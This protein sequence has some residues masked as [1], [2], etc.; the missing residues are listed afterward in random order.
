MPPSPKLK[1]PTDRLPQTMTWSSDL[2]RTKSSTRARGE[3]QFATSQSLFVQNS[4]RHGSAP[5]DLESTMGRWWLAAK[6]V[7]THKSPRERPSHTLNGSTWKTSTGSLKSSYFSAT[8][9]DRWIEDQREVPDR[10][11][12]PVLVRRLRRLK[13]HDGRSVL[14]NPWHGAS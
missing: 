8:M 1:R 9:I 5:V 11:Q 14:R 10:G 2:I 3:H 12:T 4:P 6:P 13:S 7:M